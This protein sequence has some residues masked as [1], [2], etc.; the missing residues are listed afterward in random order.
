MFS[1]F[2]ILVGSLLDY[3]I[4]RSKYNELNYGVYFMHKQCEPKA[5][6]INKLTPDSL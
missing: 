5:R 3:S 4:C 1:N 2:S 6:L